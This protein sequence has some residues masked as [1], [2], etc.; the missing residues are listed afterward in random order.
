M[1]DTT[2][3]V[4]AIRKRVAPK[5][6]KRAG[7]RDDEAR[8]TFIEHLAELRTRIIRSAVS[9]L[10]GF[11]LAIA[12]YKHIY[13]FVA[14][15]LQGLKGVTWVTLAPQEG[16]LVQ[17]TLCFYAAL[18]LA[19]PYVLYQACAFIFPGLKPTEKQAARILI[20]G[21]GILAVLG[22]GMAYGGV[23]PIIMPYVLAFV[24]EGVTVQ[25]RMS[26]T[27]AVILKVL[28]GFAIGF[29]FP[30]VVLVLVYLGLLSPRTLKQYRRH[31]IVGLAMAASIL[32][33]PDPYSM[34]V[35]LLPLVLLYEASIWM[36][37]LVIRRKK[38]EETTE[39][40]A[41]G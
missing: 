34:I 13:A 19:F 27:V 41:G 8:M 6:P 37:Y 4:P 12:F 33:P 28:L 25:L 20:F 23:L 9:V 14:G 24:P 32:T 7:F 10:V 36:S 18:V 1:A 39:E 2:K 17:L 31:A 38:A 3:N 22:A 26:E 30:M 11:G 29:Q 16:F 40:A 35:M 21:C 15:P 5:K